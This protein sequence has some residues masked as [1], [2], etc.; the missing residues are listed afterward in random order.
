MVIGIHSYNRYPANNFGINK[1]AVD[2]V[3]QLQE[4]TKSVTFL[5]G[6]P[7]AIKNFCDAKNLI[8]CYEDDSITQHTAADLLQGRLT[9]QGSLPVTVCDNY[10]YGSGI[11]LNG[12]ILPLADPVAVGLDPAKLNVI[13]SIAADAILNGATPGAVV[14]VVKDGKIAYQKAFGK[15]D[16]DKPDSVTLRSV[17]DMA[18]VTKICATTI[19][20]MKLYDEGRLDL[21]KHLGNYL[22]WV[23]GT[24]K[25]N[26]VIENILL[27]QAGLVSYI[28]FFRETI[29]SITKA[30]LPAIY[31]GR[32]SDTFSIRVAENLFMRGDWR[33]TMYKRILNSKLGPENKLVY[34]DNDFIFLGK[35]VETITGQPL[36]EYVKKTFY[37][38]MGLTATGFKPR[39]RFTLNRI[40]PTETEKSFRL[41]HLRGDVHD[42]G[43]A[44]FGGVAGHAGLFSTAYDLAVIMQMLVNGGTIKGKQFIKPETVKYFTAYN[45]SISH[46]GLGFDKPYKGNDTLQNPYPAKLVSPLTFGHTGYT[47][48]CV[49]ADPKSNIVYVF[50][51]NRVNPD[52]GEN[53][54]LSR[55]N[56]RGKIQDQIYKAMVN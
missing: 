29:D 31:S 28:P 33:D 53:L 43:A 11:V 1:T 45:S 40:I 26:L 36:D 50:L 46:R 54:K 38:P 3:K 30:P 55:L 56:V 21:K 9:A 7:Y 22:P 34:S 2:L 42:P 14:L 10:K 12:N 32:Q 25:E 27:H 48:T 20:V 37:D 41:Q 24:D 8:A 18:S 19:S 4:Q 13:D 49:W 51:S 16:Y 15:Y 17:F 47:G 6:N 35:I 23:R 39:E 5:F 52:G 44:M